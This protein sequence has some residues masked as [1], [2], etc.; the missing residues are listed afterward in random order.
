MGGM[1][2]INPWIQSTACAVALRNGYFLRKQSLEKLLFP[3]TTPRIWVSE[4][5]GVCIQKQ[6]YTL[7]DPNLSQYMNKKKSN[8][9]LFFPA[10]CIS[11]LGNIW[12]FLPSYHVDLPRALG[13]ISTAQTNS[14]WC[15][16][17]VRACV[18]LYTT[19]FRKKDVM[20]IMDSF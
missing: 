5:L 7:P 18:R 6:K 8:P 9:K 13:R 17:C 3:T 1:P 20:N 2:A 15:V 12:Q 4:I 16:L 11:S 19:L 10:S 14:H